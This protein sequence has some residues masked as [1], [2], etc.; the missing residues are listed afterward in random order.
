[1]IDAEPMPAPSRTSS[2]RSTKSRAEVAREAAHAAAI[3]VDSEAEKNLESELSH[4]NVNAR[5]PSVSREREPGIT[6]AEMQERLANVLGAT[7]VDAWQYRALQESAACS[8]QHSYCSAT[9]A[10]AP[11]REWQP[12]FHW[13]PPSPSQMPAHFLNT[14]QRMPRM[15]SF[16][17]S[18]DAPVAP[19]YYANLSGVPTQTPCMPLCQ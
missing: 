10:Y 3:P 14:F 4:G 13:Q 11:Q 18:T 5:L 12:P 9:P 15:R 16:E 17:G 6:G 8:V 7:N 19:E 1:M 2:A